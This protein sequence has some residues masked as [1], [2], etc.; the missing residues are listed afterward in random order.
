MANIFDNNILYITEQ[1]VRETTS[2][3]DLQNKT[4][5]EIKILISKS[6][7]NINNYLKYFFDY[8][9]Q[10]EEFKTD[11]KIA[12]F[13]CVEKLFENGDLIVSSSNSGWAIIEETT[14]DR[15]V[16]YSEWFINNNTLDIIWIPLQAE[17]ILKKYRKVFFKQCL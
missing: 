4:D 5:E 6:E 12:C 14:W 1:E 17:N 3:I 15:R 2:K 8:S 13:Y 7:K 11:L 9:K 10:T 16:R